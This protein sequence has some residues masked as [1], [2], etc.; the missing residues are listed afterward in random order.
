[1]KI[2]NYQLDIKLGQITQ[3]K[4]RNLVLAKIKNRKAD[5]LDEI[6]PKIWNT[7]KFGDLLLWFYNVVY[8]QNLIQRFKKKWLHFP[9]P[10]ER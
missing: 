9:L 8:N 2:I 5:C 3:K 10:Q 7:G 4:K 6:P 1:M